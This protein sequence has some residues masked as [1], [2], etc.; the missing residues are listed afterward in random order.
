MIAFVSGGARS[1][2]SRYA[3]DL[4]R[5]WQVEAGGR[6]YYLATAKASSTA[7]DEPGDEEMA[8][9]IARHQRERGPGWTT[10]ET[11]VAIDRAVGQVDSHDTVL[12]D[13]LT[14]WASQVLYASALS[15]T[16]AVAMLQAVID[17]ARTRALRLVVVSNDV[18]EGLPIPNAEVQRYLAFLQRLH[19]L[20]VAEADVAVQVRA[21]LPGYWKG[22]PP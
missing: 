22:G 12:L 19:R 18:N 7:D 15:E 17:E 6:L 10:L 2:K 14:L 1:G 9:R 5:S 13:C 21:G 20:V 4:A 16:Q 8:Q 11:P 3:E